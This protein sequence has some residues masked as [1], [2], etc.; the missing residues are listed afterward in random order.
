MPYTE[1]QRLIGKAGL[2]IKE[3]AELLGIKPN[4]ITNYSK[5]GVVPTHIAVIVA[6]I[7]TMKDEGLDF[8]PVFEKVKSYSKD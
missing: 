2:S 4:S 8:Y 5:Q 7:S 1:F 6:L 3:F